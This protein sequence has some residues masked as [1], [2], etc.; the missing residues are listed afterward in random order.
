MLDPTRTSR[1]IG[2]LILIQGA[3]FLTFWK[4]LNLAVTI[5]TQRYSSFSGK[6]AKSFFSQ[7]RTLIQLLQVGSNCLYIFL[8]LGIIASICGI[9]ILTFPKQATQILLALKILKRS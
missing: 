9:L 3:V 5:G 7:D 8:I 1:V 6:V 2:T 4:I